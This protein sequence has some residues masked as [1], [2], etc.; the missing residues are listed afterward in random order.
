[1]VAVYAMAFDDFCVVLIIQEAPN[2]FRSLNDCTRVWRDG[3]VE[4]L[5]WLG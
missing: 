1:M 2:G 5:G 3:R 4:Q